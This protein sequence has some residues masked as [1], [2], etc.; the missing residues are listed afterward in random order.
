MCNNTFIRPIPSEDHTIRPRTTTSIRLKAAQDWE[1]VVRP[2]IRE[3]D[4]LV[5]FVLVWVLAGTDCLVVG[6]VVVALLDSGV[7]VGLVVAC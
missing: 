1:L 7:D 3:A 2:R 4:T 5:I 6:V